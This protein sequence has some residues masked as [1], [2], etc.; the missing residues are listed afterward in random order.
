M[1]TK[2]YLLTAVFGFIITNANAQIEKGTFM[3]GGQASYNK[4]EFSGIFPGSE[5]ATEQNHNK[6]TGLINLSAG[7]AISKNNIVGLTLL[8]SPE[9]EGGT[10]WRTKGIGLF[11]RGYKPLGNNFYFFGQGD[12]LYTRYKTSLEG[13]PTLYKNESSSGGLSFTPGISYQVLRNVHLELS[14]P[15][16]VNINQSKT[17]VTTSETQTSTYKSFMVHSSLQSNVLENLGV[18]FKVFF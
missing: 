11:Y 3:L 4:Q 12:A 9:K 1:K 18:G 13:P 14:I 16:I 6:S 2:F 7:Y 5:N 15:N 10:I 8:Y 17:E